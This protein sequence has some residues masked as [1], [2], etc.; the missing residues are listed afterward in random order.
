M[1]L[2]SFIILLQISLL[3]SKLFSL[4]LKWFIFRSLHQMYLYP[5][6]NSRYFL[7]AWLHVSTAV[8]VSLWCERTL[9]RTSNSSKGPKRKKSSINIYLVFVS[10]CVSET[11]FHSG[12]V[13]SFLHI[14]SGLH[15][16]L[17]LSSR[18]TWKGQRKHHNSD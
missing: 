12:S 6:E 18:L 13:G 15:L 3:Q 16:L 8:N 7:Y 4:I 14:K 10:I 1:R 9:M 11:S 2:S 17:G 5:Q